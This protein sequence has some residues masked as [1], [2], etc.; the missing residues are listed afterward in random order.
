LLSLLASFFHINTVVEVLE[1]NIEATVPVNVFQTTLSLTEW[2]CRL[3]AGIGVAG[4][5]KRVISMI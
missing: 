2:V 1:M 3:I 5:C 4:P